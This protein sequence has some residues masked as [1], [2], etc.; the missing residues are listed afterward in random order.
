MESL[1]RENVIRGTHSF[2][3]RARLPQAFAKPVGNLDDLLGRLGYLLFTIDFPLIQYVAWADKSGLFELMERSGTLTLG[4]ACSRTPLN[5]AGADAI[6]GLLCALGLATRTPGGRYALTQDAREF[7]LRSSPYFIA[8]Q[9]SAQ[10][11]PIPGAYLMRGKSL[12][13]A[14]RHKVQSY[15]PALRFGSPRR[16]LNQHARNLPACAAAVRTGEFRD[17]KCLVDLAGGSGTFSI[18][19]ALDNEA[20]RIVLAELPQALGNIRPFLVEHG[21]EERIELLGMSALEFPWPIPT[22]DGIFIGNFLHAFGDE[23]CR[24]LCREAFRHLVP[25]GKIWLHEIIW[26]ENKDGPLT[27]ALFNAAI[28]N[29]PGRQRTS[30]ELTALLEHAGFVNHRVISTAG[31]Y[32]L[33]AAQKPANEAV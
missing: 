32:A 3:G 31:G 33:I 20:V 2:L 5:E 4:D 30:G 8:D 17:V 10:R 18:P 26:N 19:L 24:R 11:K 25:G 14:L 16:L 29:G 21:L 13:V 12:R 22:C 28:R 23:V 7:C 15:L 6:L 1:E 9:L 27:T